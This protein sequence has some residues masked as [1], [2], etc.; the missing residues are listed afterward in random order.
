M[1]SESPMAV[2]TD[3][4]RRVAFLTQGVGRHLV[5]VQMALKDIDGALADGQIA[6]AALQAR[7]VIS[8]CMAIRDVIRGGEIFWNHD[9]L[10]FD[11]FG[12]ADPRELES[13]TRLLQSTASVA[14]EGDAEQIALWRSEI[15]GFAR[16]T[17]QLLGYPDGLP[18]L[19]SPE[20]MFSALRLAQGIFEMLD[21]LELPSPLPIEW[22]DASE[23]G[24]PK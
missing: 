23:E 4:R 11:P 17:E 18:I 13:V 21:E 5:F 2:G 3:Y 14:S 6:V 7:L 15:L 12:R 8:E 24:A 9:S 1:S 22:V 10:T 20:G 19:R 16:E